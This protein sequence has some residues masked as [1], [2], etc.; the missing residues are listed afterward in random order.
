MSKDFTLLSKPFSPSMLMVE[1]P[2]PFVIQVMVF[3]TLS[4]SSKVSKSHMPSRRISL[5]V[6]PSLIISTLFSLLTT[7]LPKV[8]SQLGNKLLEKSKRKS[9][10]LPLT[11][12]PPKKLLPTPMST[13]KIM[14]FQM[15]KLS[16]STVQ[17]SWVQKLFSSQTSSNK[18]MR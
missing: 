5:L 8:V 12:L 15:V 16:K 2:V 11:Q 6:E 4:Q 9:A 17:D 13:R 10:L 1:P 3:P 7:S 18:E 14:N